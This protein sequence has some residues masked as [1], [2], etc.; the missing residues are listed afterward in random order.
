MAGDQGGRFAGHRHRGIVGIIGFP[1]CGTTSLL[2]SL[3]KTMGFACCCPDQA[4]T[5]GE[6]SHVQA[7]SLAWM[8]RSRINAFKNPDFIYDVGLLE[9]VAAKYPIELRS[10]LGP[11]FARDDRVKFVVMLRDPSEWLVSYYWHRRCEI[12]VLAP[13][14]RRYVQEDSS[15]RNITLEQVAAGE[16]AFLGVDRERGKFVKQLRVLANFIPWADIHVIWLEEWKRAP[17]AVLEGLAM[18]LGIDSARH[19]V[20]S[21]RRYTARRPVCA[22]GAVLTPPRYLNAYYTESLL[23]LHRLLDAMR[24]TEHP[25]KVQQKLRRLEGLGRS[26]HFH[27]T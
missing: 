11:P 1:R 17:H 3:R 7:T 6:M 16:A 19:N 4:A 25:L 14:V 9:W 18:F 2:R 26:L 5:G 12:E 20:S 21:L 13:W 8:D 10:W 24:G 23:D 15:L 22:G 27:M